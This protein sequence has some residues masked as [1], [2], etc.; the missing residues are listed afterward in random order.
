[1]SLLINA[2]K[3]VRIM[4]GLQADRPTYPRVG[5]VYLC[6]DTGCFCSCKEAGIW[7]E[8]ELT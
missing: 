4:Q 1:M 6:V 7:I 2:V 5:D 3:A 8:V